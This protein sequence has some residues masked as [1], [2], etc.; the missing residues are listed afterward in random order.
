M[1]WEEGLAGACSRKRQLSLGLAGNWSLP[2][3]TSFWMLA[4]IVS[5]AVLRFHPALTIPSCST[6][7][8]LEKHEFQRKVSNFCTICTIFFTNFHCQ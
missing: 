3:L 8:F 2:S 5:S 1:L 7:D 4:A 6:V